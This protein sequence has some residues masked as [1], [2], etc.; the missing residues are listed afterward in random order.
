M[1]RDKAISVNGVGGEMKGITTTRHELLGDSLVIKSSPFNLISWFR[2]KKS[3]FKITIG[4]DNEDNDIFTIQKEGVCHL[5]F[6]LLKQYGVYGCK[7]TKQTIN[8]KTFWISK[9]ADVMNNHSFI[10]SSI[11]TTYSKEELSR[12]N[13]IMI[14]H[15]SLSHCS[16]NTLNSM[17]KNKILGDLSPEDLRNARNLHGKCQSCIRGK[18]ILDKPSGNK[19][20]INEEGVVHIDIMYID[21]YLYLIGVDEK[22]GYLTA[23]P[24][25]NKS[26]EQLLKAINQLINEYSSFNKKIHRLCSDREK[27][28]ISIKNDLAKQGISLYLSAADSHDSRIER[29]I[30]TIKDKLRSTIYGMEYKI[31]RSWLKYMVR[32]VISSQN[33]VPNNKTKHIS[34]FEVITGRKIK[35]WMYEYTFGEVVLSR[36]TYIEQK[37]STYSRASYGIVIDREL[38]SNHVYIIYDIE[39]K[40]IVFRR[41]LEHINF[42]MIPSS[43]KD[44]IIPENINE[45]YVNAEDITFDEEHVKQHNNNIDYF[46]R[47]LVDSSSS[48]PHQE[49]STYV[50]H[51]DE[52]K[53]DGDREE[54]EEEKNDIKEA[55]QGPIAA[56]TR[57]KFQI[58]ASIHEYVNSNDVNEKI[59]INKE[60]YTC[61]NSKMNDSYIL[62]NSNIFDTSAIIMLSLAQ[63]LK[64]YDNKKVYEALRKEIMQLINT[65]TFT[66]CKKTDTLKDGCIPTITLITKKDN[67][68]FKARVVANGAH[69]NRSMYNTSD[70][71]SPTIRNESISILLAIAASSSLKIACFD[72][73]GAYLHS[74]LPESDNIYIRFR[75]ETSE[76]IKELVPLATSDDNGYVYAKLN[77]CLYGLLQSGA[78][79]YKLLKTYLEQIGYYACK[80]DPCLYTKRN[81]GYI[82][83]GIYVDDIIIAY[84]N[85][86]DLNE[87][88]DYLENKFGRMKH[89]RG[90]T[91][92]Y[93]GL[94]IKQTESGI[95]VNQQDKIQ[96]LI[97]L[98]Y[99][100]GIDTDKIK[101][102]PT[103]PTI[104][105]NDE[106][107][108]DRLEG[109]DAEAFVTAVA[110]AIYIAVMCRPDIRLPCSILCTKIS[111][112][113][114]KDNKKLEWLVNYLYHTYHLSIIYKKNQEMKLIAE[115][116]ASW[117]SN[118]DYTGQTG[119]LIRLGNSVV[120]S[121]SRKQQHIARSSAEAEILAIESVITEVQWYRNLLSEL[122]HPQHSPTAIM[123]DNKSAITV[124]EGGIPSSK[125]K[126]LKWREMRIHEQI[127]QET[128][129]LVH[130]SSENLPA[131]MMTK[132]I[133]KD[134]FIRLRNTMLIDAREIKQEKEVEEVN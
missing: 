26:K 63:A 13:K 50:D 86:A 35:S 129:K 18:L 66:P 8:G 17:L 37:G 43:I 127:I 80:S 110:K 134:L 42:D 94:T 30:R 64:L 88:I 3:G 107:T 61:G 113:T 28:V 125:T 32:Y 98:V 75:K 52:S 93:R 60:D 16:D 91:I 74:E 48:L 56:R 47:L 45:R 1:R 25:I 19:N 97:Q 76:M 73:N 101:Y 104:M 128:I 69:Q 62:D 124:L 51:W 15:T 95:L 10:G 36:N 9:N 102:T 20:R 2:L 55:M 23:S 121:Y 133:P 111:K 71:S 57:N 5:I 103:S 11:Y 108:D 112:P 92:K 59:N 38:T 117:L 122:G 83:V 72:V 21:K 12:I 49:P 87:T 31:P 54:E 89:H 33:L 79:W 115:V 67:G 34:P 27:G 68:I 82:L 132:H 119:C 126:H 78:M 65:G 4:K 90:N 120:G 106:E 22:T 123:Q 100:N 7:I 131:D 6:S 96:E 46:T 130:I 109:A 53:V 44:I 116:D 105:N 29:Q 58:F 24:I 81:N 118:S 39:T 40:A 99:P 77:K 14:I 114:K 84:E 41:Q 85:E 70:I